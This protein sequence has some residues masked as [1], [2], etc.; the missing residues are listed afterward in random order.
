MEEGGSSEWKVERYLGEIL[1]IALLQLKFKTFH[2]VTILP[3]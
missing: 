1:G 3:Y 2:L